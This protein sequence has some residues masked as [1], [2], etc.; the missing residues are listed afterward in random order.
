M[1]VNRYDEAVVTPYIE[2]YTPIP[3][4]TLYKLGQ[5]YN[6]QRDQTEAAFQTALQQYR[7]FN[8]P[9]AVDT[10]R[11]YDLTVKPALQLAEEMASNPEI[12]RTPEGR[13]RIQ[14]FI[15]TRPYAQLNMLKQNK[16]LFEKRQELEQKLSLAGRYN[17]DWHNF[18]YASYDT[19]GGNGRPGRGLL[20]GSDL[21]LVPYTSIQEL[22]KPYTDQV[23]ESLL[24]SDGMYDY[25]GRSKQTLR[26]QVDANRSEILNTPAARMH[27]QALIRQGATPQDAQDI[28]MQQAYTAADE[29]ASIRREPNPYA[30]KSAS[31]DGTTVSGPITTRT[32]EIFYDNRANYTNLL[33]SAIKQEEVTDKNGKKSKKYVIDSP[34]FDFAKS[35]GA[36]D[37]LAR[38][39]AVM[40]EGMK[41]VFSGQTEFLNEDGSIPND[42]IKK[43]SDA[44]KAERGNEDE[45]TTRVHTGSKYF[46]LV[47]KM[48]DK[49]VESLMMDNTAYNSADM[50]LLF[51]DDAENRSL[52][53]LSVLTPKQYVLATSPHIRNFVESQGLSTESVQADAPFYAPLTADRDYDVEEHVAKDPANAKPVRINGVMIVNTP[54]G[55]QAMFKV[56]VKYP[57]DK[58]GNAP[59][60]LVT[61]K[62]VLKDGGYTIDKNDNITTDIL[63]AAPYNDQ[64]RRRID[65]NSE[66]LA[67]SST[68]EKAVRQQHS[69]DQYMIGREHRIAGQY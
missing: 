7:N 50:D 56:T 61:S 22:V 29:R 49:G 47:N 11:W 3:F 46:S 62:K 43:V 19:L 41:Q 25:Y 55:P 6:T 67:G 16:E 48:Y 1:A 24:D 37:M 44:I 38:N 68:S 40:F 66:E 4:D 52:E 26:D 8:S 15:N 59:G 64:L 33:S 32:D 20:N 30:L 42:I 65:M 23:N 39:E 58:L 21:N 57:I 69:N 36:D 54:Q 17:Y 12:L 53:G 10:Q 2:Q 27:I 45:K 5:V 18:D 9:S 51:G 34:V 60:W 13:R 14:N 63:V 28:F 35:Q 31:S